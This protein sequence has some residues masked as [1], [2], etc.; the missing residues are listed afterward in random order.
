M[1]HK[2]NL[3]CG[4]NKIKGYVNIDCDN[5]LK[6]DMVLDFTKHM[7]PYKSGDVCEILLFH[8]I[9]HIRKCY[10]NAI[11]REFAR[12]LCTKGRLYISYPNF[13]ECAQRWHQNYKGKRDFWEQTIYGRQAFPSDYHVSAMDPDEIS[14]SL[15]SLGFEDV[16]HTSEMPPNEYNT[17]TSATRNATNGYVNYEDVL[18]TDIQ[19]TR[20]VKSKCR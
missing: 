17:I 4:G 7:L 11:F 6:P 10:H 13:W 12:V 16:K 15:I 2:L 8:T 19:S 3:G 20:L 18:R 14:N 5:K 1:L 9:E